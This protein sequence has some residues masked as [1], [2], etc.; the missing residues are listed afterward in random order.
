MK[1]K[2]KLSNSLYFA[3]YSIIILYF[4][5]KITRLWLS[6][7]SHQKQS[8]CT[9]AVNTPIIKA[10]EDIVCSSYTSGADWRRRDTLLMYCLWQYIVYTAAAATSTICAFHQQWPHWRRSVMDYVCGRRLCAN[11]HTQTDIDRA[12]FSTTDHVWWRLTSI[13]GFVLVNISCNIWEGNFVK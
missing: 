8:L 2:W 9:F 12:V 4:I 3:T 10:V 7:K 13:W 1:L 5:L 11:L 6:N